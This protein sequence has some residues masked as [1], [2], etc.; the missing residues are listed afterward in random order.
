MSTADHHKQLDR[1]RERFTRTAE[2][3]AKFSLSTRSDE[4]ELLVRLLAPRGQETALD[5]ACGPGTFLLALA[6]R[7]KFIHGL[8]LTLPLIK[9]AQDRAANQRLT[10]LAFHCGEA[11]AVPLADASMDLAVCGYSLHHFAEPGRVVVELARVL[12]RSAHFGVVDLI[13]PGAAQAYAN[14]EI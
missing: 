12:R 14:N 2:Q 9:Q 13:V 11:T 4:A 10:N 3:F 1:V 5:L 7:V 6:P 8:D